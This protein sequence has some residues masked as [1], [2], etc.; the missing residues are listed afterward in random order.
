MGLFLVTGGAGFIGSNIVEELLN[1][2]ERVRV[3][4]NL[5][6]G[7]RDN[8]AF[9]E[10]LQ[11]P[12]AVFEFVEGDIR[13]LDTCRRACHGVDNVLHQAALCSVPRSINDP[14]AS[15]D[16]NVCG[17][18]TVLM[19]AREAGVKRVVHASSSSV[20][21]SSE[22]LPKTESQAPSPVSPYAVSKIAGEYYC[23]VFTKVFGLETVIL[24]YFNVFG[25]RQDPSSQYAAVV[26]RFIQLALDG[27]PLQ[28]HGDG[29]QSRDF[30]YISNV[31]DANLRAAE[32][33]DAIGHVINIACGQ[34]SSVL[35]IADAIAST[36]GRKLEY[37][38]TPARAGDVRHSLADISKAQR[39]LGYETHVGVLD[40]L[41]NTVTYYQNVRARRG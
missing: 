28:I 5:S 29:L 38:H 1:R 31:V 36:L 37:H 13:H 23:Q 19:A 11:R 16:V 12:E 39:L 8:L 2:G 33:P 24:R 4:D 20:Y 26:P 32:A 9:V 30:T 7:K 35:Q 21:G 3:L 27:K 40:G 14:S 22:V 34:T 15:N 6:T 18:L 17:T 25:P 41:R 10:R